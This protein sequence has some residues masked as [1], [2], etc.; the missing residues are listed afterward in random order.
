MTWIRQA[1]FKAESQCCY[2]GNAMLTG[3]PLRFPRATVTRKYRYRPTDDIMDWADRE[4]RE[5]IEKQADKAC[6]ELSGKF[7]ACAIEIRI[8]MTSEVLVVEKIEKKVV[9]EIVPVRIEVIIPPE[10]INAIKGYEKSA[11]ALREAAGRIPIPELKEDFLKRASELEGKAKELR[12]KY[13][14]IG[15]EMK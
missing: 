7:Y 14:L 6:K 12:T 15:K 3:G 11:M 9:P 5:R 2:D 10:I 4:A 8:I 13:G 1:V